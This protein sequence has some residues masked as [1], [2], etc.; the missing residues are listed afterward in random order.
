MLGFS[1]EDKKRI[2][3]SCIMIII[4]KENDWDNMTEADMVKGPIKNVT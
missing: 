1:E 3:K 2:W 4:N